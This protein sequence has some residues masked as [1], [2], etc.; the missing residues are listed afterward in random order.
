MTSHETVLRR[1]LE[2]IQQ[3]D[4]AAILALFSPT[5][6]VSHPVL[7][8][9]SAAEFF[10]QLLAATAS[11]HA[12]DA[13]I[14]RAVDRRHT[15]ALHFQ[16]DWTTSDGSRFQNPILLIFDFDEGGLAERL[17]VL[18]DTWPMRQGLGLLH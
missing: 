16:D 14:F 2:A 17:T 11:D 1:Y 10:P 18:F 12:T 4:L 15:A 3:R 5:A 13:V 9:L 7:G 8:Q 6:T